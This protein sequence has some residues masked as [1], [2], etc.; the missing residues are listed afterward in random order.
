M[1][2]HVKNIKK[3]VDDISL[4]QSNLTY[5]H[6]DSNSTLTQLRAIDRKKYIVENSVS[7]ISH[8]GFV[9]LDVS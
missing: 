6:S 1:A 7:Y 4:Y 2:A 9:S 5:N 3:I 8:V